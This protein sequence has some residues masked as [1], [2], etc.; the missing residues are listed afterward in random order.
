MK[1]AR[2]L[3]IIG[4]RLVTPAGVEN[5]AIRCVNGRIE[6]VGEVNPDKFGAFTPGSL[7]PIV[8]EAGLLARR[9]DYL[10][11]LP[12]HFRSFFEQ[13]A[14]FKGQCLVFPLPNLDIRQL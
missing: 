1:Q 6:A 9:P 7:I 2:P 4:G 5:G 13:A 11:V 14:A 3:V 12:W 8:D 10:I